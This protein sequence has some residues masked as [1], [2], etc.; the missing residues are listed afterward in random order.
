MLRLI[1]IVKEVEFL[2]GTESNK[3][4]NVKV[5]GVGVGYA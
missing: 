5:V 3:W 2:V 1:E 4:K